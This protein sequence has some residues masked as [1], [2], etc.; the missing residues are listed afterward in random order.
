[1]TYQ[2]KCAAH[3]TKFEPG[4]KTFPFNSAGDCLKAHQE[5]LGTSFL[6][7]SVIDYC[8]LIEEI[9]QMAAVLWYQTVRPVISA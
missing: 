6:F 1:M 7:S 2:A 9:S 8:T 4:L 3:N 5:P